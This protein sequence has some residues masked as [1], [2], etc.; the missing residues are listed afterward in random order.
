MTPIHYSLAHHNFGWFK[1][2][3]TFF[4]LFNYRRKYYWRNSRIFGYNF[5]RFNFNLIDYINRN[6]VLFVIFFII[7]I[8][9]QCVLCEYLHPNLFLKVTVIFFWEIYNLNFNFH[10]KLK[11]NTFKRFFNLNV[12]TKIFLQNVFGKTM[13]FK[14]KTIAEWNFM[15][16]E[17]KLAFLGR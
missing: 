5:S 1:W 2:C 10:L 9:F 13:I 16:I 4:W 14:D 11:I 3:F 8:A 17:I 6:H 7:G 15:L 12:I